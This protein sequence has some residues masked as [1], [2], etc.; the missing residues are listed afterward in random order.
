VAG[1]AG[2]ESYGFIE[3]EQLCIPIRRHDYPVPTP[4]LQN[5]RDPAPAFVAAYDFPVGIVQRAAAG[6][7]SSSRELRT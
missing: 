4:E 1:L 6:C 5:A 7:P 2:G 3:E